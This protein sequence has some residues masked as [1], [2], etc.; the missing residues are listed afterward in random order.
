MP[1]EKKKILV[2]E[3][4]PGDARF[5][6]EVFNRYAE[7]QFEIEHQETLQGAVEWLRGVKMDAILLDLFLPDGFGLETLSKLREL[8]AET[9]I[10]VLTGFY[11]D[12]VALRALQMGAHF[13]I[14]KDRLDGDALV[15]AVRYY[16][17]AG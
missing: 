1:K 2:V 16:A 17:K 5:L 6:K 7:G 13:Y 12:D 9:P 11:N 3:D 8:E 4:N 10:V 15:R 14:S